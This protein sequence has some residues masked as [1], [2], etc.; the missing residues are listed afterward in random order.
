L[1]PF[2][3]GA[4]T[5]AQSGLAQSGL[6][7]PVWRNFS[8]AMPVWRSPVW[9]NAGLAQFLAQ[10]FKNSRR[11][12]VLHRIIAPWRER[13]VERAACEIRM[14]TFQAIQAI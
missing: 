3:V 12:T 9:R 13:G 1:R 5:L 2:S 10:F 7:Q 4:D 6:A 11:P 8:G 14:I